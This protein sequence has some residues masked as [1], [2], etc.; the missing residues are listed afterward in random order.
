VENCLLK[1]KHV[2]EA[3]VIAIEDDSGTKELCA[4]VVLE[5]AVS[6]EELRKHMERI[7]PSY[8]IPAVFLNLE[9]MPLTSNG[10]VNRK[11]LP[12]PDL[13]M[14]LGISYTAPSDEVENILVQIWK[15]ILKKDDI[16]VRDDFFALGGHSL[17]AAEITAM[18]WK[19]FG[20]QVSL[21]QIFES[22]T[23]RALSE[24]VKRLDKGSVIDIQP[25]PKAEVY[26]VSSA[27]R[28][29]M[30]LQEIEGIED[31]YNV[32]SCFILE[33]MLDI[34]QVEVALQ[35]LIQ[36]HEIL[37]TQFEW[38]GGQG[39]QRVL[40]KVSFELEVIE[41][42]TEYWV[43]EFN[44]SKAPLIRVGLQKIDRD[45]HMLVIDLH[46][47]ITD[48]LSMNN[49]IRDFA[50]FYAEEPLPE[51]R[52]QYKDYAVWEKNLLKSEDI[53][54]QELYWKEQFS[55]EIPILELPYDRPR[56]PVKSFAGSQYQ[57]MADKEL[58]DKLKQ[59]SKET[60][61]RSAR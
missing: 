39:V 13:N 9:Q 27:Q 48:G 11:G 2:Q 18:I 29:M 44:L 6:Y 1:H 56:P 22:P 17:I 59:L 47:I 8:M 16:G 53:R 54:R 36:R 20:V 4:Y 52:I 28:R 25:A 34:K 51:M 12:R 40:D 57:F 43:R 24:L 19:R 31:T 3:V 58:T 30:L 7:V 37:R 26:P 5:K 49:L 35:R 32:P 15:E 14:R 41:E 10:K 60:G 42:K 46:H 23:I 21:R 33:G 50:A 55:E 45:R 61:E 38:R